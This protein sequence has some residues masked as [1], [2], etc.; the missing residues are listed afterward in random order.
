MR[1]PD[2]T[3]SRVGEGSRSVVEGSAAE[4]SGKKKL[5]QAASL[6]S[7]RP[8][9]NWYKNRELGTAAKRRGSSVSRG[10]VRHT[11]TVMNIADTPA[12]PP[13]LY[14]LLAVQMTQ[15]PDPRPD[16]IHTASY[17]TVD[18]DHAGMLLELEA[19]RIDD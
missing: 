6:A 3:K 4:T 8:D 17:E 7:S 14:G 19:L 16:T 1:V 15:P 5:S 9:W 18:N 12:G 13:D 10:Q 2:D 11:W